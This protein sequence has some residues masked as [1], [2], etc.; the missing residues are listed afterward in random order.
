MRIAIR[1]HPC[2]PT[3]RHRLSHRRRAL[4]R[5]TGTPATPLAARPLL[6]IPPLNVNGSKE[7]KVERPRIET[8]N[9]K[10]RHI[11]TSKGPASVSNDSDHNDPGATASPVIDLETSAASRNPAPPQG[12]SVPAPRTW[13]THEPHALDAGSAIH[14]SADPPEG[15]R[16]FGFVKVRWLVLVLVLVG[17]AVIL[18]YGLLASVPPAPSARPMAE[19][20]GYLL[21]FGAVLLLCRAAGIDIRRL[22]GPIPD[23]SVLLR[24]LAMSLPLMAVGIGAL[25]LVYLPLSYVNP[26]YVDDT[27]VDYDAFVTGPGGGYPFA[28]NLVRIL[29]ICIVAPIFEEFLFRGMI[30]HR[31]SVTWSIRSAVIGSS[32]FF[33]SLHLGLLGAAIGGMIGSI[34]YLE[35][36]SLLVPIAIHVANN[37]ISMIITAVEIAVTGREVPFDTAMLRQYWWFGAICLATGGTWLWIYLRKHWRPAEWTLPHPPEKATRGHAPSV[38]TTG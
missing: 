10:G 31:W 36:R 1:T 12:P 13:I 16:Q 6:E 21:G 7:S 22:I 8:S 23:R 28:A 25:W 20:A 14:I 29:V 19:L 17:I 24:A 5:G 30:L 38:V 3:G 18:A 26:S 27:F 4:T 32:I 15:P 34:V 35:T 11:E 9:A 37:S 33:G 2:L